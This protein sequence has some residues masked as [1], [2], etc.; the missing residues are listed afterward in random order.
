MLT[1]RC[2]TRRETWIGAS[3]LIFG[4]LAH[5]RGGPLSSRPVVQATR[6][7]AADVETVLPADVPESRPFSQASYE[8]VV[9]DG[10]IHVY[11]ETKEFAL[12]KVISLPELLR[13]RGVAASPVDGMLY[14]SYGGHG[15]EAG[16]GSLLKYDLRADTVVWTRRLATGVDSMAVS[17]DGALIYMPTGSLSRAGIWLIIEAGS[18]D[19]IGQ[20]DGAAGP[21]NTVVGPDGTRVYLGGRSRYLEVAD[22]AT[23][24][25][26]KRIG[27]LV[28]RVRPFTINGRETLAF[29]TSTRLLGFQVSDI[30]TGRVLYTVNGF[31]PRFGYDLDSFP[32][33]GPSHGISLSPDERELYV[34]DS[35]NRHVHVFD[36]SD[37]PARRPV[38]IADIAVRLGG[39]SPKEGWVQHSGDGRF[40]FVGDSGEV[41]DTA[42]RTVVADLPAL[43]DTRK[44]LDI[45]WRHGAPVATSTR[46]GLGRVRQAG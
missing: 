42:T 22:A 36:V 21:H 17:A 28:D 23:R 24:H 16:T 14:V 1:T 38:P 41:I 10:G 43:R 8:Y 37:V 7:P 19:I 18:G 2:L 31:G 12:V 5:D 40:V 32:N 26:V 33:D 11:D 13:V 20:I 35:P 30:V 34:I 9:P 46:T 29:T 3:A 25:V 39:A 4:K 6:P 15:G 45:T 44:H 27:P